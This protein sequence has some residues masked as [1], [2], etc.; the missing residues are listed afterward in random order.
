MVGIEANV[1]RADFGIAVLD[2]NGF[3]G[4]SDHPGSQMG[5]CFGG[6]V[7]EEFVLGRFIIG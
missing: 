6:T 1:C 4:H 5:I 2:R 3:C 7:A